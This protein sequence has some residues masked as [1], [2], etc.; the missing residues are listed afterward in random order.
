VN[1][2]VNSSTMS[3]TFFST[4]EIKSSRDM[5]LGSRSANHEKGTLLVV[6]PT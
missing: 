2:G 4:S 1:P 5:P 6:L 3:L